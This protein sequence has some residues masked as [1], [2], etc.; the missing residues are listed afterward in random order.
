[1][2]LVKKEEIVEKLFFKS[3]LIAT[4]GS[5]EAAKAAKFAFNLVD[6]KNGRVWCISI[7]DTLVAK[8]F[9]KTTGEGFE[10][11]KSRL[12]EK[13]FNHLKETEKLGEKCGIKIKVKLLEG[14]P[15]TEIVTF[16]VKQNIDLIV[17][18][19][20][21]RGG[22]HHPVGSVT[23]KVIENSSCCVLVVK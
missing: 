23:A 6:K 21:G 22:K 3:I 18:G 9:S 10:A 20:T 4:D 8:E 5:E 16:A 14:I 15:H 7:I 19:K 1:M 17:M 11:V 12:H 13:C 2:R